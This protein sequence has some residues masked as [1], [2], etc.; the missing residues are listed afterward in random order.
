MHVSLLM[1]TPIV[2]KTSPS[3]DTAAQLNVLTDLAHAHVFTFEQLTRRNATVPHAAHN[4]MRER[5]RI[6]I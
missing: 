2:G 1:I 3:N 4:E 5:G 6:G